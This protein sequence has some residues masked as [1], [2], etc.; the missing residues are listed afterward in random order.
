LVLEKLTSNLS[1]FYRKLTNFWDTFGILINEL[2]KMESEKD[3]IDVVIAI[4]G[5]IGDVELTFQKALNLLA[6]HDISD[7][8]ISSIYANP[9]VNCITGTPDFK[10]A[11]ILCK[12]TL[13]PQELLKTTQE[14]EIKLGRPSSHFSNMSRTIDLDIILYGSEIIISENLIIPHPRA[15]ERL[16]VIQPLNEIAPDLIFPNTQHTVSEHFKILSK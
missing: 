7:I 11:V 13:K 16:F 4:G 1:Q 9:P 3:R 10:N 5:N 6:Q 8:R 2:K 12:T 14:I 15:I